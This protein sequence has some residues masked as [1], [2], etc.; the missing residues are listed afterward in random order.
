VFKQPW[1]EFDAALAQEA[2]AEVILQVNGKLRGK[3][4]VP[5]G[6]SEDEL[7]RQALAE[8]K[9]Q[10]QTAGKSVVR[11]IVVMDKLVNIVVK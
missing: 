3:I 7:K 9:V 10:S 8:P 11:V 1:P 2:G 6:T 5:F 4:T